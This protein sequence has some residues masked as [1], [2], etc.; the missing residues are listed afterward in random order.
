M[1]NAL[2]GLTNILANCAPLYLMCDPT[3]INV[4][5]QTKSTFI[6][7]PT[8]YIYDSYPG[9]VGFSDK[10]Y[11]LHKELFVMARQMV[12]E[13]SCKG[14]CPSCVGPLN[15]FSGK[16]NPKEVTLKLIDMVLEDI[17]CTEI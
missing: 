15:E 2:M 3:D 14:G 13:C 9:G 7:R 16:G 6:Q 11:A 4:V 5:C 17:Q 10:L 12:T 1:Q 8:I